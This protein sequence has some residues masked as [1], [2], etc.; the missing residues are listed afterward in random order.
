MS[1]CIRN[2]N[3]ISRNYSR[4]PIRKIKWTD[5]CIL[6]YL[7]AALI[8]P[9][10]TPSASHTVYL[11]PSWYRP[12]YSRW[13]LSLV[14]Y[15]AYNVGTITH[16]I[17]NVRWRVRWKLMESWA[18]SSF[19]RFTPLPLAVVILVFDVVVIRLVRGLLVPAGSF[20]YPFWKCFRAKRTGLIAVS[21]L[22]L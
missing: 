19:R 22:S 2:E 9:P 14:A 15:I 21:T 6:W 4:K 20:Y 16:W 11:W 13:G 17:L 8:E 18:R 12:V 5:V 7:S 3:E 1:N 10:S